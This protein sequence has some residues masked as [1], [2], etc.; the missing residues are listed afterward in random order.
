MIIKIGKFQI[1]TGVDNPPRSPFSKGETHLGTSRHSP[2]GELKAATLPLVVP[3]GG[4]F[5][6][7]LMDRATQEE[8]LRAYHTWV[9]RAVRI[10]AENVAKVKM[11]VFQRRGQEWE[12]IE[13]H[14]I[15]DLFEKVNPIMTRYDLWELTMTYLELTGNSYWYKVRDR[16]GVVRELWPLP[17][18]LV[19]PVPDAQ[20]IL[21]GYL[22]EYQG[23][24]ISFEADEIVHLKYPNPLS[25]WIG[26]GTLQAAAYAFDA[27]LFMRKWNVNL[28]KNKAMIDGVLM[29]DQYLQEDDV[30]RLRAQWQ[31][32]Y[33]G[34]ANARKTAL[35]QAGVKYEPIGLSPTEL[36]FLNSVN[37]TRNDI[38]GI[39]G[40]PRSKAGIV[41]DVNRANAE[42]EDYTF[43]NDVILPKLVK[44]Y[45]KLNQDLVPDFDDE[46]L[47]LGF[48]SPVPEDKE[49]V[50]KQ[51][52]SDLR[53]FVKSPNEV[54]ADRGLEPADWGERP[55][56]GF[57]L[58]PLGMAPERE[59]AG[60]S[61]AAKSAV[62]HSKG[63]FSGPAIIKV[64][65]RIIFEESFRQASWKQFDLVSRSVAVRFQG[66]V[67]K[68]FKAQKNEVL[69][70]LKA[71]KTSPLTAL[72]RGEFKGEFDTVDSIL[73]N[74]DEWVAKF[75]V[76]MDPTFR[77][78]VLK[79]AEKAIADIAVGSTFEIGSPIVAAFLRDKEF[80]FSFR[81]NDET[82]RS[83]RENLTAGLDANESIDQLTQRVQDIF[84]FADSVRAPRIAQTEVNTSTN[85]GIHDAYR[86]SEVVE[87]KNWLSQ[88]DGDV[89]ESHQLDTEI[90]ALA[91]TFSNGLLYPGDPAGDA[92]EIINCRCTTLPV[93]D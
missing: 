19:K 37:W 4:S 57:N 31:K 78:A 44:I 36:D 64:R 58:V 52:E 2:Q 46:N 88:R 11:Q 35:L 21:K 42:A 92:S 41:E 65:N 45:E 1:A 79:G 93:V 84:R 15:I 89:R 20:T 48:V 72:Q 49:F 82:L 34:E 51:D 87:R 61:P 90:V 77:L 75:T 43:S 55:W 9:F 69:G 14:P 16:L 8:Y 74:M 6:A 53:N 38:L 17:P 54:R 85:F 23:K 83:L 27:D 30:E 10:I 68:L 25:I 5:G 28:F 24:R 70:R 86:Q 3:A 26:M 63:Y 13:E 50:L 33:G 91:E 80:K 39:F 60:T 29:T 59:L 66:G 56:G 12:E 47:W 7:G 73:F 81:V 40:V 71:G 62:T 32:T 76:A 18:H 67:R 22:F